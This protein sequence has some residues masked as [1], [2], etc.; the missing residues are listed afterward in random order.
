VEA[1]INCAKKKADKLS[2]LIQLK[3]KDKMT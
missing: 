1:L 2:T 3:M